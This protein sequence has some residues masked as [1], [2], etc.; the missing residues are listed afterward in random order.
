MLHYDNEIG[1][2]HSG[3][4]T[5]L[6]SLIQ[7]LSF[8]ALCQCYIP[9]KVPTTGYG[10]DMTHYSLQYHFLQCTVYATIPLRAKSSILMNSFHLLQVFLGKII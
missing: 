1:I 7:I 5:T 10:Y 6:N 2:I 9:N 4:K 3:S 8:C